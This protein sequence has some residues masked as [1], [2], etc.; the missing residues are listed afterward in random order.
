[1]I[2]NMLA[3]AGFLLLAIADLMELRG[4]RRFLLAAVPGYGLVGIAMILFLPGVPPRRVETGTEALAA[5]GI[6]GAVLIAVA[7]ASA[8]LLARTVF[9]EP[10]TARRKENIPAGTAVSSGSYGLCRHPGF[11][12][13]SLAVAA[14]GA[15]N[16]VGG[17]AVLTV[18]ITVSIMIAADL[19]LIL[20][21]DCYTFP[22][23]LDG[24]EKYRKA[25]PFLVPRIPRRRKAGRT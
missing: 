8:V 4:Q 1:M 11:W 14:L 25:V 18:M 20:L 16:M 3:I 17:A 2:Q 13:F 7:A 19:L 23:I 9:F 5:A 24:Y 12:W 6:L 21:Q 15:R 10:A 22:R